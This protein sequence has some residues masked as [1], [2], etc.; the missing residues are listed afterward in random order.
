MT[1]A[2]LLQQIYGGPQRLRV[3]LS[4]QCSEELD[5]GRHKCMQGS[6]WFSL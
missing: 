2:L 1:H 6:G 3:A 4:G 5:N